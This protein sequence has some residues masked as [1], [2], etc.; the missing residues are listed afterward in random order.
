MTDER[1]YPFSNGTWVPP[2][3]LAAIKRY[4]HGRVIPGDFLQAVICNDLTGAVGRA[5]DDNL[6]NLP[7]FV[8]YFYNEAPSRCWGSKEKMEAW[9]RGGSQ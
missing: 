5:D 8:G 1:G 4:I 3:M 7:A 6:A 9:L 2:E